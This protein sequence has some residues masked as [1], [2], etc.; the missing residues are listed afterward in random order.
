MLSRFSF[1]FL[2]N[3]G[4]GDFFRAETLK[5]NSPKIFQEC[6]GYGSGESFKV[7]VPMAV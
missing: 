4:E 3:H 1:R 6:I 5:D 7:V 2:F